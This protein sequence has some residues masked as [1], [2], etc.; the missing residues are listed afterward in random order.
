MCEQCDV[1]VSLLGFVLSA[2]TSPQAAIDKAF[3]ER[4]YKDKR[5]VSS[6]KGA[7]NRSPQKRLETLRK[8][9]NPCSPVKQET[10]VNKSG[11]TDPQE[12]L[13]CSRGKS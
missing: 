12:A 13:V 11:T 9:I 4:E 6:A 2:Q 8:N 5:N 3:A 1:S 10:F 7:P